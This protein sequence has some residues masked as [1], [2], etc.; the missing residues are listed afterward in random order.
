MFQP[1]WFKMERDLHEG[2]VVLFQKKNSVLEHGWTFGIV[3]QLIVG[4]DGCKMRN[5]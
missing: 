5:H 3:D 2:D 1:K 4:R